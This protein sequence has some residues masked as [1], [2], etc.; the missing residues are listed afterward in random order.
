MTRLSRTRPRTCIATSP[1]RLKYAR[2][3]RRSEEQHGLM[4]ERTHAVADEDVLEF[5]TV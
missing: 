5:D 3:F 1:K 2:L 4:V